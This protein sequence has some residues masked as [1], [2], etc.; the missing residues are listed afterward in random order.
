MAKASTEHLLEVQ[1]LL[2]PNQMPEGVHV[3]GAKVP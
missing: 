2:W 3:L 1:Q